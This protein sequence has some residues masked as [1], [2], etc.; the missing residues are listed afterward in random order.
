[1][2]WLKFAKCS[3]EAGWCF[4]AFYLVSIGEVRRAGLA[5]PLNG[6]G[7][8]AALVNRVRLSRDMLAQIEV[9]F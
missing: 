3:P 6:A 8:L 5:M 4:L 1:V 7:R 9:E 2:T